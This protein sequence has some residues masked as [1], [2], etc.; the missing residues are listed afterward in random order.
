MATVPT[1]AEIR[2]WIG[3]PVSVFSDEQLAQVLAAELEI[4]AALCRIPEDPAAYPAAAVEGI[5][6][7]VGRVVA[8][9]PLPLGMVGQDA[10]YGLARLPVTDAEIQRVE[11]TIRRADVLG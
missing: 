1:L 3:V 7:R 10:E 8:A 2:D 9:R 5:Y 6:R 11:A 4:Q